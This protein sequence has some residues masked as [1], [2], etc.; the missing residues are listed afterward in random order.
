[1]KDKIILVG[2]CIFF[3]Q[4]RANPE[5]VAR[6]HIAVF[7]AIVD[8]MYEKP[9]DPPI[10]FTIHPTAWEYLQIRQRQD[11]QLQA[12]LAGLTR[13]EADAISIF[14]AEVEPGHARPH[15]AACRAHLQVQEFDAFCD[16]LH[17]A[18]AILGL[19]TGTARRSTYQ[20]AFYWMKLLSNLDLVT[21]HYLCIPETHF[22]FGQCQ[23]LFTALLAQ[24]GTLAAICCPPIQRFHAAITDPTTIAA[25]LHVLRFRDI[26]FELERTALSPR[27]FLRRTVQQLQLTTRRLEVARPI[28]IIDV[29]SRVVAAETEALLGGMADPCESGDEAPDP[30][31]VIGGISAESLPAALPA[32][33]TEDKAIRDGVGP[34]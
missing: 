3:S 24:I 4:L 34:G 8:F 20:I 2:L 1:M 25:I 10:D 6:H 15:A 21:S 26:C 12:A 23:Q 13:A 5:Q 27:N 22:V 19:Q 33:R 11:T 31:A 28:C 14:L 29:L 32:S 16:H 18:V 17:Q 9:F 30:F 7:R